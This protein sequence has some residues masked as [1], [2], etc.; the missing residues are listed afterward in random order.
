MPYNETNITAIYN[1]PKLLFNDT[2]E[3]TFSLVNGSG[4][5][6]LGY[7]STYSRI[8]GFDLLLQFEIVQ[9]VILTLILFVLSIYVAVYLM[10]FIYD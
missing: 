9:T 4:A 1:A 8:E 7:L 2:G 5:M 10:R 6:K 3:S